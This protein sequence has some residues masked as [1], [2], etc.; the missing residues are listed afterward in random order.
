MTFFAFSGTKCPTLPPKTHKVP[1]HTV[2]K[3]SVERSLDEIL[4]DLDKEKMESKSKVQM[5]IEKFSEPE[6]DVVLRKQ[7][8]PDFKLCRH[9]DELNK[10]LN[11]LTKVTSAP[12]MTPGVTSS[13][14]NPNLTDE[15]VIYSFIFVNL[16]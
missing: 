1:H 7:D 10:L 15:E 12:I 14:V 3:H 5:L 16:T 2:S 8:K 13:L 4:E 6:G 11:E 9:S